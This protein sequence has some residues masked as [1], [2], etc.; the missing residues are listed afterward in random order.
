MVPSSNISYGILK[1]L[2]KEIPNQSEKLIRF[3][4]LGDFDNSF[5]NDNFIIADLDTG[6]NI[7]IKNALTSVLDINALIV[8]RKLTITFDYEKQKYKENYIEN[9]SETYMRELDKIIKHCEHKEDSEFT[10]SDFDSVEISQGE[11]DNLFD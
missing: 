6:N 3:N 9:L 7:S 4:Y 8:N 11:L 10:P 1:Y 2:K 5:Q